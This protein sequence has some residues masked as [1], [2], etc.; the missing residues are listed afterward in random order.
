MLQPRSCILQRRS[1]IL[2]TASQTR[3]S[4]ISFFFLIKRVYQGFPL[5]SVV[6]NLPANVGGIGLITDPGRSQI[7]QSN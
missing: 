2:S 3:H 1:K 6:K 5:G 4:Q 7:L